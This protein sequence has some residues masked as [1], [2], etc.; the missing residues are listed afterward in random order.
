MFP[1]SMADGGGTGDGGLFHH[2]EK[3]E[4]QG[5]FHGGTPEADQMIK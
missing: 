5:L 2:P 4:G 3:L 1:P